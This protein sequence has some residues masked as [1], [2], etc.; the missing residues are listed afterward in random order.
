M[1]RT[2]GSLEPVCSFGRLPDF[3]QSFGIRERT[4]VS[5]GFPF[6]D[7]AD[8]VSWDLRRQVERNL[9]HHMDLVW[10]G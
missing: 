5:G 7:H 2:S 10:L 4:D 6:V 9:L 1:P 8:Q 3:L